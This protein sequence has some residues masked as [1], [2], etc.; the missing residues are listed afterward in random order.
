MNDD[1][2]T[3]DSTTPQQRHPGRPRT[4]RPTATISAKIYRDDYDRLAALA[5][6][7]RTTLSALLRGLAAR[8]W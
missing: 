7:N 1:H 3:G 2:T 6:R 8:R 4:A 5:Q